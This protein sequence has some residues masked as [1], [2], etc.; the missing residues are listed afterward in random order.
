M[1]T[2]A[3]INQKGGVGK[4]TTAINLAAGLAR[5]GHS[6]LLV[7]LDPQAH[8][9]SGL[10]LEPANFN[11]HTIGDVLITE[12]ASLE[13]VIVDT[14]LENLK[15]VPSSIRLSR[16]AS[17]LHGQN[18]REQRLVQA[19]EGLRPFDY[20]ILDCQPSLEVL[21]VNAMVAANYFL[22]PTQAAGNALRGLSDLI[23]TLQMIKRR[24]RGF[25][26]RVLLTMVMPQAKLTNEIVEQLL[27][28]V[29]ERL[30]KTVIHRNERLNR[31]QT[32]EDPKDI[33]EYDK[34]CRGAQD[35]QELI[36]EISTLWPAQ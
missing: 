33:F 30:L 1:K 6:T 10:G 24:A 32:D 35:Y 12:N 5:Q 4:T 11:G 13:E 36:E 2:I 15:L 21:P 9:T 17:L 20:V 29:R 34:Q 8:A 14:Y 16:T 7:D 26:W 22:I 25:D 31:A 23:E 19:M 27:E 3:I 18:F 28:P